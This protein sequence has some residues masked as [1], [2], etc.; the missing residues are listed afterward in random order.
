M[1]KINYVQGWCFL[2]LLTSQ[3]YALNSAHT[4]QQHDR[5]ITIEIN[6]N[7]RISYGRT[8]QYTINPGVL[9]SVFQIVSDKIWKLEIYLIGEST[10]EKLEIMNMIIGE[11]LKNRCEQIL[12]IPDAAGGSVGGR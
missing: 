6:Q 12:I 9:I 2:L 10:Q 7:G 4:V 8:G 3:L 11:A 1:C 5:R